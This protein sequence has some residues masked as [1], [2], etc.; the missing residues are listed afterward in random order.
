[1]INILGDEKLYE[2]TIRKGYASLKRIGFLVDDISGTIS[3]PGM[4]GKAVGFIDI[5]GIDE[6]NLFVKK[7][8]VSE[9]AVKLQGAH[10]EWN[11]I[12]SIN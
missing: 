5:K 9:L 3:T 7:E 4:F 6:Y 2:K 11:I 8:F 1:M 12:P 10:G